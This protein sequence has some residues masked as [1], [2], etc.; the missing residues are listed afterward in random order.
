MQLRRLD[1]GPSHSQDRAGA[2]TD[3]RHFHLRQGEIRLG[4][5][6]QHRPSDQTAHPRGRE[7]SRGMLGRGS[8]THRRPL[9]GHQ[10]RARARLAG[11][12]ILIQMHERGKLPDAE[13]G[14]RRRGHQ[15]HR[16][17]LSVLPG[18]GHDGAL[19]HGRL[20]RRLGFD[21]RYRKRR[22]CSR[23]RQQHGGEPS[24]A[25]DASQE[26]PQTSWSKADRR[27]PARA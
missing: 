15:Q 3:Q 6:R 12:H 8:A 11:V 2:R 25:R 9:V 18:A 20:R 23:Y 27:R 13:V 26:C 17:L 10:S 22:P 24:G 5:R 16:Q 19:S 1:Q 21:P 4:L 7:V 14:P